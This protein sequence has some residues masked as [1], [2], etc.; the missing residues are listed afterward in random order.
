MLVLVNEGLHCK[1]PERACKL[2]YKFQTGDHDGDD[3]FHLLSVKPAVN[4]QIR[5]HQ[6][7]YLQWPRQSQGWKD[8][9]ALPDWLRSNAQR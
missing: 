8:E 1:Q 6:T 4:L 2:T 9:Q 7:V 3:D 5:T